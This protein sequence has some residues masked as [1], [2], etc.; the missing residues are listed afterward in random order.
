[1]FCSKTASKGHTSLIC[2]P[3]LSPSLPPP[4]PSH[5]LSLS[6]C[7]LPLSFRLSLSLLQELLKD[8]LYIGLRH[9]RVRGK[10]YDELLEE[11]MKAVSDR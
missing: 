3:P 10:A 11:F 1:M 7:S 6:P 5:T 8:P 4:S 9:K 2:L